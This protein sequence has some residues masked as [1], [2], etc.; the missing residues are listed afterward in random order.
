MEL[1][2]NQKLEKKLLEILR[3]N[4]DSP[5]TMVELKDELNVSSTSVVFHHIQQLERKGYLK[6]NPNNSKDYQIL[7]DPEKPIVYINLYG[8]ITFVN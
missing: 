7:T 4:I 8:I 5:L 3:V 2:K 1:L 6:R